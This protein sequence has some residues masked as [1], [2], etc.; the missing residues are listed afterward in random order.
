MTDEKT[1]RYRTTD[2]ATIC[3]LYH[4][5]FELD[6]FERDPSSPGKVAVLFERTPALDD[7]LRSLRSRELSVEPTAFL[8]TTRTV[9]GRL[10]D[11]A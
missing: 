1:G 3:S 6:G 8:E 10:R 9:R 11:C 5:G 4:L 7:A 2:F